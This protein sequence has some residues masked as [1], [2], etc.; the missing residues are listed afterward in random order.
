MAEAVRI[1]LADDHRLFLEGLRALLGSLGGFEVV[2]EAT[3]GAEAVAQAGHLQPDVILMDIGMPDLS[4]VE[5]TRRILAE[6][7]NIGVLMITMFDDAESVFTAMRA[8]ER[9]Y[10]LKGA[11]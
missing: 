11:D 2:G 3:T 10:V 7:P 6:S 1:L 8:R 9:G 5:A 4:G